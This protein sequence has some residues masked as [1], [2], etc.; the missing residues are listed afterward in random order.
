MEPHFPLVSVLLQK[1]S[2]KWATVNKNITAARSIQN[3][4]LF[5]EL[6]QQIRTSW[7]H[8]IYTY[9]FIYLCIQQH[10]GIYYKGST[11]MFVQTRLHTW[12]QWTRTS[13]KTKV[14]QWRAVC[15]IQLLPQQAEFEEVIKTSTFQ[16][17]S[18]E[19]GWTCASCVKRCARVEQHQEEVIIMHVKKSTAG[20]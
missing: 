2:Q 3:A 8:A 18:T 5:S 13:A 11:H 4:S 14:F 12:R 20:R 17:S 9:I 1:Y 7:Q 15:F 10:Q 16:L 19:C 6:M